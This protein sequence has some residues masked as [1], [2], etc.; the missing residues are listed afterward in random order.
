ML[1]LL[2]FSVYF[3]GVSG[4]QADFS[5]VF[6]LAAIKVVPLIGMFLGSLHL[7]LDMAMANMCGSFGRYDIASFASTQFL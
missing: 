2:A 3:L 5:L 1:G 7:R 6:W 4:A